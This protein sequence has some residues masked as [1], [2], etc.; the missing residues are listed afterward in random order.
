MAKVSMNMA[1][2]T[3][4]M[5]IGHSTRNKAREFITTQKDFIME[6]GDRTK[7]TGKGR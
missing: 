6:N 3:T 4:T 7:K 5:A 2:T 1:L